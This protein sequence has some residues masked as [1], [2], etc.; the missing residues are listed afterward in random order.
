MAI[1]RRASTSPLVSNRRVL[2]LTSAKRMV[3][4]RECAHRAQYRQPGRE[5]R[6]ESTGSGQLARPSPTIS[7]SPGITRKAAPPAACRCP[8]R[9][10]G[11]AACR[12]CPA[13]TTAVI[14]PSP[15]PAMRRPS[16]TTRMRAQSPAWRAMAVVV[17]RLQPAQVDHAHLPAVRSLRSARAARRLIG[18]PLPKLKITRSRGLREVDALLA[19]RHRLV[20]RRVGGQPLAVAGLV[21]VLGHVQR[22]RL[23]EGARR[24]R[25]PWPAPSACAAC[26]AASSPR[27]GS[28]RSGRGCR[29][30]R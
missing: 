10:R 29:A 24:G 15:T 4:G 22:D 17:Q 26:V 11:A 8:R 3:W 28:R 6:L 30:A 25:R 5:A 18:T 12:P 21:Q 1:R 9:P 20:R 19:E 16:S 13:S 14:T 2:P 7:A 23:Q 27:R